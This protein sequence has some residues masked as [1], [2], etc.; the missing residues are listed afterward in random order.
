VQAL[1]AE[2]LH[3]YIKEF[4]QGNRAKLYIW[5]KTVD[6]PKVDRP[7]LLR[8]MIPDVVVI[9]VSIGYH[10]SIGTILI[11]NMAA[12]APRERVGSDI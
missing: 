4:N 5:R 8:F 9:Y 1:S 6:E 10:G 7:K 11:E 12:F 3:S 2:E